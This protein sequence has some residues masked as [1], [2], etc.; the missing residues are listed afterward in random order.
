M[1]KL[2]KNRNVTF[3]VT[4]EGNVYNFTA[5]ILSPA[6]KREIDVRLSYKFQNRNLESIP[7]NTYQ[8]SRIC[9]I[10][11]LALTKK[12]R[13]FQD[14]EDWEE[15]IDEGL[16]SEIFGEYNEKVEEF[17]Q[18]LKKNNSDG[19]DSRPGSGVGSLPN[20]ELQPIPIDNQNNGRPVP[21]R[22]VDYMPNGQ[23]N[24][25]GQ[26][27]QANPTSAPIGRTPEPRESNYPPR[28]EPI[29]DLGGSRVY[30]E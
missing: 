11:N 7:L 26:V 14:I 6:D 23:H 12:P 17:F 3:T 13:A 29:D 25:Y 24:Q 10:L 1:S 5:K 18:E 20:E 9:E 4:F 19:N 22:E 28:Q 2:I 16:I 27:H 21:R 30:R 15:E 8:F